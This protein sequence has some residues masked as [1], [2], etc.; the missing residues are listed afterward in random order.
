MEKVSPVTVSRV[1]RE[2]GRGVTC[3]GFSGLGGRGKRCH[4][5]RFLVFGG[6]REEVSHVTVSGDWG[7]KGKGVTCNGF[8]GLGVGGVGKGVTCYGF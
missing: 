7:E 5:L 6:R 4:M 1:W 8:W 2:E 3:D